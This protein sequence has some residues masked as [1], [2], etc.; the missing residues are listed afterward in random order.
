VVVELQLL[1]VVLDKLE[2]QIKVVV[3]VLVD[4]LEMPLVV[5]EVQVLL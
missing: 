2:Q 1:L 5:L 4:H 3:E